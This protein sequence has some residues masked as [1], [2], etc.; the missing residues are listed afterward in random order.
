MR[1]SSWALC[2]V[3][4]VA[5]G[6]VLWVPS[7]TTDSSRGATAVTAITV[8]DGRSVLVGPVD[9][10]T[11]PVVVTATD[12]SGIKAV[13]PIG[14]WGPTYG[15]LKVSPMRCSAQSATSSVC[16]GSVTVDPMKKQIF[17]D[18]VGTWFVDLKVQANNGD[19]FVGQ[20]A[21]GFSVKRAARMTGSG[22]PARAVAGQQ[23]HVQGWLARSFWNDNKYHG[24]PDGVAHLQFRPQGSNLWTTVASTTSNISGTVDATVRATGPGDYQWYS[25][26]DK[27]TGDAASPTLPIAIP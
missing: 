1:K 24:Y 18:E 6:G 5:A 22:V 9:P 7:I 2:A 8:N 25:P 14:V 23:L 15:L 27:W 4:V 3:A 17:N 16:R 26:G 13:D 10:V 19:R 12:P 21:G 20:T 11:F